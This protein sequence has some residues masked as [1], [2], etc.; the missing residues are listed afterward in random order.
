MTK[1]M[2]MGFTIIKY[3][4]YMLS[5]WIIT[6]VWYCHVLLINEETILTNL[7]YMESNKCNEIPPLRPLRLLNSHK[8]VN[9]G[10]LSI[11]KCYGIIMMVAMY[12]CVL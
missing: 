12:I 7:R 5:K 8:E 6:V 11:N 2:Y 4:N 9:V 10:F 3:S 1:V